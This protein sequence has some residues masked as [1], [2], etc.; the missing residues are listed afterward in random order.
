MKPKPGDLIITYGQKVMVESVMEFMGDYFYYLEHP[1]VVPTM[2][3]TRDY[4]KEC[5][6]QK[7]IFE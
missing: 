5:E 6:V 3:Y 4:I 1:I 2:E 7:I